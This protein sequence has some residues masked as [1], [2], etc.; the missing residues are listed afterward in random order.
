MGSASMFPIGPV[1]SILSS[2][3]FWIAPIDGYLKRESQVCSKS[4]AADFGTF[5]LV[6]KE[7]N[8]PLRLI[9]VWR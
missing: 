4:R 2:G 1:V 9:A 6:G 7:L 8:L 5:D 3:P